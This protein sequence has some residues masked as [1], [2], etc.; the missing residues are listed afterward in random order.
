MFID[1][2]APTEKQDCLRLGSVE[3]NR[4]TDAKNARNDGL[5]RNFRGSWLQ[6]KAQL[7]CPTVEIA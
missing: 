5:L 7:G 2:L 1:R 3:Y 6:T 4:T